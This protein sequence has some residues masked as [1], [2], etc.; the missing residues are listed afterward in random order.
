MQNDSNVRTQLTLFTS[1]NS[2]VD[3][4]NLLSLPLDNGILYV[5]PVYI[6]STAASSYPL[7]KKV[8]LSYGDYVA[9]DNDIASGI[10]DLLK[11][12]A[13]GTPSTPAPPPPT[14]PSPSP[15]ATPTPTPPQTTAPPA[16]N[17]AALNAAIAQINT[18][19][20]N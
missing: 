8:L 1:A 4:G 10:A 20:Q 9:F 7:M 5:E 6:R 15:S 18:A 19:L 17:S 16:P 13:T 11:Q 14:N 12:A 2:Q 3:Y